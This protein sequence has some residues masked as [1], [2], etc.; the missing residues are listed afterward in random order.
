MSECQIEQRTS[1][2]GQLAI[3]PTQLMLAGE[4]EG[5]KSSVIK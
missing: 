2:T 5:S 3:S 4:L 1:L